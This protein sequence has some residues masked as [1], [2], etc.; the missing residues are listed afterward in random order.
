MAH[1]A[2]LTEFDKG[3]Q[4]FVANFLQSTLQT[5]LELNV[6]YI[7]Q[8]DI[9]HIQTLHTLIDTL[10]GTTGTVVPC[11]DTILAIASHFCREEIFVTGNLFQGFAQYHLGLQMTVIGGHVDEI[12][13]VVDCRVYG[14]DAF[15]L[16]DTVED[17]T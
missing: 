9:I 2:L 13:A 14:A 17:T 15:F 6:V 12:D 4:S 11:V 5:G 3:R 7:D 1:N 10:G 8:V 16:T